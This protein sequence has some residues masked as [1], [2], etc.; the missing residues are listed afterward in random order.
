MNLPD[1]LPLL[2][3]ELLRRHTA[4]SQ[5][6]RAFVPLPA[7]VRAFG[8]SSTVIPADVTS[9]PTGARVASAAVS[10]IASG[11]PA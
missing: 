8:A 1:P 6:T 3:G 2:P 9:T 4:P 7:C 5:L 11:V 10:A